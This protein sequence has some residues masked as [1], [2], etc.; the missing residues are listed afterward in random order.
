MS[1][2]EFER[3]LAQLGVR[4][5]VESHG[6]VAVIVPELPI[7]ADGDLRHRIV[8]LARTHGFTNVSVELAPND[9][10]LPGD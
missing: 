8:K 9:A 4:G 3:E 1:E 5:R 10:H 6:R 7:T 2:V